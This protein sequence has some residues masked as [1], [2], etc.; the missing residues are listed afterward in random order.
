M[1]KID[2]NVYLFFKGNC[3]EAMEFYKNI[4]GGELTIQTYGDVSATDDKNK[5]EHIMHAS[6]E[7]GDVKLMAS[8]TDM[9]SEKAAKVSLSLGG[10]DEARLREIFDQLSEDVEVKYPLKKEFWGDIFGSVTDKYGVEWMV[11]IEAS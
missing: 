9:A 11:N 3:R 5:A 4:F 6:L 10:K 8:D 2:L 7:G 1:S